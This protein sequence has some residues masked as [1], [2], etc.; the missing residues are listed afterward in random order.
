M[1]VKL[2]PKTKY[3]KTNEILIKFSICYLLDEFNWNIT[4]MRNGTFEVIFEGV[5]MQLV[6][7]GMKKEPKDKD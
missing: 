3:R 7:K 5:L 1:V 4:V 2:N 6:S